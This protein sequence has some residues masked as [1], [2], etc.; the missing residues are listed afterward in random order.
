MSKSF[1]LMVLLFVGFAVGGCAATRSAEG[2]RGMQ[3]KNLVFNPEWTRTPFV[4]VSRESDWPSS[5]AKTGANERIEFRETIIDYQG[6]SGGVNDD[7]YYRR[8]YSVRERGA[9]R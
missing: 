6:R 9:R 3:S 7:R 8:L 5:R 2:F 4:A 1:N